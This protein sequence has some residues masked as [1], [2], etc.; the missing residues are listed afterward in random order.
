MNIGFVMNWW[1]NYGGVATWAKTLISSLMETDT[2]RL[3]VYEYKNSDIKSA[4]SLGCEVFDSCRKVAWR[5][6]VLVLWHTG[7]ETP[8][9]LDKTPRPPTITVSHEGAK[10]DATKEA[11]RHQ[12]KWSSRYV[13]VEPTA[14]GSIPSEYQHLAVCIPNVPDPR[15][16]RVVKSRAEF[17]KSI[18]VSS[19]QVLLCMMTRITPAKG[20]HL[21]AE[22]VR[23]LGGG[24]RFVVAGRVA[25]KSHELYVTSLRKAGV[26]VLPP[27]NTSDVL[28]AS[29]FS[30][31][32]SE[33]EGNSY[34][35]LESLLA[36]VP[37]VSTQVGLLNT[38]PQLARITEPNAKAIAEAILLDWSDVHGRVMR[39]CNSRK[40]I[41]D[42]ASVDVFMR[43]WRSLL[44][45]TANKST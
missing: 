8:R 39:A 28:Y 23:L 22:A 44:Y 40:W 19:D 7:K 30:V 33:S 31:S 32:A 17:R 37:V 41:E 3:G 20:I 18:G 29:D 15:L 38:N 10:S 45:E 21:I 11:I 34:S 5:S 9:I 25:G 12:A 14:I 26:I 2:V 42:N 13:Y 43:N 27:Q 35:L 4:K 16:C 24:F 36:G 1:H 6:D